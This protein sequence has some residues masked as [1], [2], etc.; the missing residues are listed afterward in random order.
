MSMIETTTIG[1]VEV[2]QIKEPGATFV[3]EKSTSSSFNP[4][5]FLGAFEGKTQVCCGMVGQRE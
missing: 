2:E 3:G 5:T 1:G 4:D